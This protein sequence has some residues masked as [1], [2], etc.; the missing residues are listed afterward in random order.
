MG[1]H[2]LHLF[3]SL[4]SNVIA[5]S[6]ESDWLTHLPGHLAQK[7]EVSTSVGTGGSQPP[8]GGEIVITPQDTLESVLQK[9]SLDDHLPLF[10]VS[11]SCGIWLCLFFEL[12]DSKY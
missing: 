6:E 5:A 10:K 1:F 8:S 4:V 11:I 9:L 12:E 2:V 3:E 7:T